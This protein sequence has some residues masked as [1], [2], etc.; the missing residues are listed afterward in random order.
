MKNM[1]LKDDKLL[2]VSLQIW[3]S[4]YVWY[5][6]CKVVSSTCTTS[7][8]LFTEV[9]LIALIVSIKE[10]IQNQIDKRIEKK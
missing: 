7:E 2:R 10:L 5:S 6:H 3:A 4:N 1:C 9:A 8:N